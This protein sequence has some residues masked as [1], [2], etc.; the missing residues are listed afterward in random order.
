MTDTNCFRFSMVRCVQTV[1]ERQRET[2]SL[3][4]RA[5]RAARNRIS[6]QQRQIYDLPQPM[7]SHEQPCCPRRVQESSARICTVSTG[8][9]IAV[10]R[11][12][13]GWSDRCRSDQSSRGGQNEVTNKCEHEIWVAVSCG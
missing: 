4:G 1:A 6:S 10:H 8:V 7:S 12:V 2:K 9:A 13:P 3:P 5:L 11:G